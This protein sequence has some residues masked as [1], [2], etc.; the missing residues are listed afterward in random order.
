MNNVTFI[1]VSARYIPKI[2]I[3]DDTNAG[4]D[5]SVSSF[6]FTLIYCTVG[7]LGTSFKGNG[8]MT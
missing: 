4:V 6:F 7:K 1:R 5:V 8:T 3:I 2:E